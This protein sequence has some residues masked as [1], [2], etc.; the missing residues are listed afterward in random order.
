VHRATA[1]L[2]A[3]EHD[4]EDVTQDAMLTAFERRVYF[5]GADHFRRW[6]H[7]IAKATAVL[8]LR[9]S[10]RRTA[11]AELRDDLPAPAPTP[12]DHLIREQEMA[13]VRALLAVRG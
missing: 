7:R 3:D 5:R 10:R 12:E 4:A 1:R 2:V 13:S 9:R 8:H 6:L 11:H